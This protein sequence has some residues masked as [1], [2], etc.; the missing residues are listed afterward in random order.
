MKVL[1]NGYTVTEQ[2]RI[3]LNKETITYEDL[4]TF[5]K[6][7]AHIKKNKNIYVKLVLLFAMTIDSGTLTVLAADSMEIGLSKMA[8]TIVGK[9]IIVAKYSCMGF[10]LK[11]MI[12]CLLNGGN[13]REASY[14]GLQYWIGYLALQFYPTLYEFTF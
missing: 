6:F 8:T 5:D 3:K 4:N 13:M 11:E 2:L 14:A 9:L 10:G 12:I 1:I 7:I